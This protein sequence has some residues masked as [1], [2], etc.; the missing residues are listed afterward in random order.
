[1]P[2]IGLRNAGVTIGTDPDFGAADLVASKQ[3]APTVVVEIEDD[4]S[5]QKEQ[6]LYSVL[7]QAVMLMKNDGKTRYGL[8]VP[9]TSEWERQ[10]EKI[11]P[12]YP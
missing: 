1:M 2:R 3:A 12:A 5:K 9:D 7:G 8:A 10:L 6:A 4:S 11:P